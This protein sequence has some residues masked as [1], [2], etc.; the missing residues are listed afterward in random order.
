MALR[1]TLDRDLGRHSSAP[2]G[3]MARSGRPT[4]SV[5]EEG[6]APGNGRANHYPTT[7][8]RL[9]FSRMLYQQGID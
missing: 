9:A 6:A 8:K 3:W 1:A 7:M 5:Q 4:M 2:I